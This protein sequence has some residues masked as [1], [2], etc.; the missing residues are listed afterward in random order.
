MR[1]SLVIIH[2]ASWREVLIEAFSPVSTYGEREP[3][4]ARFLKIKHTKAT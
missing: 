4:I 3:I 1:A 2:L